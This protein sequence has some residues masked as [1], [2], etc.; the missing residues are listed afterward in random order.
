MTLCLCL[1]LLAPVFVAPQAALAVTASASGTPTVS[2][3]AGQTLGSIILDF[4]V[5]SQGYHR[6]VIKLPQDFIVNSAVAVAPGTDQAA[7]LNKMWTVAAPTY[8]ENAYPAAYGTG[9][10]NIEAQMFSLS[11]NQLQLNIYSD[12]AYAD[13]KFAISLSNTYVPSGADAT[14]NATIIKLQGDFSDSIVAVGKTTAGAVDVL[15]TDPMTWGD[16]GWNATTLAGTNIPIH[17]REDSADAWA[18]NDYMKLKLPKGFTWDVGSLIRYFPGSSALVT[19]AFTITF[20]DSN[21]TMKVTRTA[22]SAPAIAHTFTLVTAVDVNVDEAAF[23]D[24]V[25]TI[26]GNVASNMS[27]VKLG[28]YVDYGYAITVDKP[29]TKVVA[30]LKEQEISKV[31]MKENVATSLTNGRSVSMT[32]PDGCEWNAAPTFAAKNGAGTLSIAN[33]AISPTNAAKVT[34]TITANATKGEAWMENAEIDVAVDF[35]GPIEIQFAGSAGINEKITVANAVAP[36]TASADKKDLK[37]GVQ[38]QSAGDITITENFIEAIQ[39]DNAGATAELDIA[40]PLGVIWATMPTVK[41]TEGDLTLGTITRGTAVVIADNKHE[42]KIPIRTQGTKISKIVI[43]DIKFTVDRTVPEGDMELIV[44]GTALDQ[45]AITNRRTAAKVIAANIITPAP[46]QGTVGAAVGQFKISSNIYE[47]NGVAKVMDA[48][49]YIKAGRT[50]VPIR[51]LGYALGLSDAEIVWD[52]ATQKVTMTKGDNVVELTIGSTTITVNGE[53]QTM[54]VAPE[55]SNGRTML[56]ARYVAEGLGFV[57]GWDPGSQTV[58]I[59]K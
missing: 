10:A 18:V 13:A 52:D 26:T 1:A 3:A 24:V 11:N 55:I 58:L 39:S 30:G 25:A 49:P 56:P 16:A 2:K 28:T 59:S 29:E 51:F 37:I 9:A 19:D 4:G 57:V 50:Y 45:S 32:L 40:A 42:L 38:N 47:V 5:I 6:A 17:V 34:G 43:S 33:F 54:D 12:G 27:E 46:D 23:G 44:R 20:E 7:L 36:I 21:R 14:I 53:A 41:V 22:A 35:T 15:R 48:A 8:N 31:I